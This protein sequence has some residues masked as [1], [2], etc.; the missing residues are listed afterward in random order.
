MNHEVSR[1]PRSPG[2]KCTEPG[3][4]DGEAKDGCALTARKLAELLQGVG[5]SHAAIFLLHTHALSYCLG[6]RDSLCSFLK[7]EYLSMSQNNL[8]S[9]RKK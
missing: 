1:G 6:L 5:F 8:K 4:C 7:R 9:I 2:R 3:E